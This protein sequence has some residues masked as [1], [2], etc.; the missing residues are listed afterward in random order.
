MWWM[1]CLCVYEHQIPAVSEEVRR[2]H[3][4]P[5]NKGY[6]L[7]TATKLLFCMSLKVKS[8]QKSLKEA[9]HATS[10][11]GETV[12]S[13]PSWIEPVGHLRG[14]WTWWKDG[15]F[16]N[17]FIKGARDPGSHCPLCYYEMGRDIREVALG[18]NVTSLVERGLS[19]LERSLPSVAGSVLQGCILVQ[20][21]EKLL[22]DEVCCSSKHLSYEE[23]LIGKH[24]LQDFKQRH[25]KTQCSHGGFKTFEPPLK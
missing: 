19:W 18:R 10:P 13:I 8:P 15:E 17:V 5:W 6:E 23:N 14:D 24:G 4:I 25:L 22:Q 2:C 3:W 21:W 20:T 9:K 1:F 12:T 7:L 11:Q 16:W